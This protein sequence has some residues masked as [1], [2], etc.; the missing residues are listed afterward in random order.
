MNNSVFVLRFF[1]G[2]GA[3]GIIVPWFTL[4]SL[5]CDRS[6]PTVG[7]C[8]VRQTVLGFP[9][10]TVPLTTLQG[11]EVRSNLSGRT[12]SYRV[13]LQANQQANNIQ[14]ISVSDSEISE[15]AAVKIESFIHNPEQTHLKVTLDERM[16]GFKLGV[17]FG[18]LGPILA[19][20]VARAKDSS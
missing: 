12:I 7:V 19:V 14:L 10:Q 2:M 4:Q 5:T 6:T 20:L 11:A 18:L 8:Q 13:V 15:R 3:V 17:C 1:L 16:A 9:I